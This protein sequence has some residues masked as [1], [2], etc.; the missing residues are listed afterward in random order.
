M[1]K[2]CEFTEYITPAENINF[3][4][5]TTGPDGAVWFTDAWS[6]NPSVVRVNLGSDFMITTT[7]LPDGIVGVPY[8]A[9]LTAQGGAPAVHLV[10]TAVHLV[11][12]NHSATAGGAW[13]RPGYRGDRRH[14]HSRR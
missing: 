2:D 4:A 6:L 11:D 1:R 5:I 14:A 3:G 7:S 9:N 10:D 8:S 13:P 12:N